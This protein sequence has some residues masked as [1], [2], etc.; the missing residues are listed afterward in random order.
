[1]Q[2]ER[3]VRHETLDVRAM[4]PPE[5]LARVMDAIDGF[6]PGDTLTVIIDCEPIPLFRILLR[7][8]YAYSS[9]PG[10]S[11]RFEIT[12]QLADR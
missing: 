6:R 9:A 12:I 2:N 11:S 3:A 10:R 8:G 4:E 1:M 7:N 5:P